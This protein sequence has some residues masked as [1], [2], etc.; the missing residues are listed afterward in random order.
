MSSD[1]QVIQSK[2]RPTVEIAVEYNT[3]LH[4]EGMINELLLKGFKVTKPKQATNG[5]LTYYFLRSNTFDKEIRGMLVDDIIGALTP[6]RL[7]RIKSCRKTAE[8]LRTD[9]PARNFTL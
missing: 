5:V 4:L 2:S 8:E 9:F 6:D 7:M 1:T 3:P